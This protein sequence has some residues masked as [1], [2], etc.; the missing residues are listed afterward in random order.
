MPSRIGACCSVGVGGGEG[1]V[2][3][4][5]GVKCSRLPQ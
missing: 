1:G 2:A 4:V 3:M 5:E